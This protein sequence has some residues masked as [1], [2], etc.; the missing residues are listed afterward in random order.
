MAAFAFS[1]F[2]GQAIGAAIAGL[3]LPAL[4]FQGLF[5]AAALVMAAL[6]LA[7]RFSPAK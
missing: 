3:A 7:A 5:A 1:L 4:G 2:V 6:A